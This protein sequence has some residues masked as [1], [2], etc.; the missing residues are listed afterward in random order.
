MSIRN[1]LLPVK[2]ENIEQRALFEEYVKMGYTRTLAKLTDKTPRSWNTIQIWSRKF[3]WIKRA[4]MA[5]KE[6]MENL[7]LESPV[8]NTERKRLI[9]DIIN[10]MITDIA[11]VDEKGK[12]VGTTLQAKNVFDLRTL[13]DVRNEILGVKD[14]SK[15]KSNQTNIDKAIFIIKK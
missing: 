1:P 15:D 7:S 13:V 6:I 3:D 11:V 12:V 8:E 4:N 14:K 10:K 5:D 2:T 9:L